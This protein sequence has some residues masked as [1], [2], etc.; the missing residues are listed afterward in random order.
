MEEESTSVWSHISN[1][2]IPSDTTAH[3]NL[4]EPGLYRYEA[5]MS[6]W[7]L[8]KTGPRYTFPYKIYGSHDHIINRIKK[9]WGATAANLGV[10]LNGVKG[11]GKTVTAQLV[12]NWAIQQGIPVIVVHNPVP[13]ATILERV[14][15][16]CVVIFDEFEK[17]HAKPEEQQALLTA[18]DGMSRNAWKRLFIFTT[19]AK[20]V[21]PNFIDRPSRIRYSWEFGRLSNEVIE[22]I[23]DDLLDPE[24]SDL[25]VGIQT[26]LATR[27]VLSIDVVKTVIVECNTFRESPTT[28]KQVMNL[29]EQDAR[30]FELEIVDGEGNPVRSLTSYFKPHNRFSQ[31]LMGHL[32]ASGVKSYI[33]DVLGNGTTRTYEDPF[34]HWA[35]RLVGPTDID[36]QVWV[37]NVKVPFR[38]TW[39]KNMRKVE[40]ENH[41]TSLWMDPRP[42]GWKVP[43]WATKTQKGDELTDEEENAFESWMYDGSVYNSGEDHMEVLVR[44]TPKYESEYQTRSWSG[45]VQAF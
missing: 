25:R 19:N 29:S 28:F 18:I 16:D 22:E 3:T 13:L 45:A 2:F 5:D 33:T 10:L 27:K 38:E 40:D 6:G 20:T 8:A 43:S 30:G 7:W 36:P 23:L 15:Q 42:E 21:D 26:Y 34:S 1:R 14:Q 4:L 37:C 32:S 31:M 35:I 17:T 24:L 12:G 9:A 41:F 11:T 44:I 39:V